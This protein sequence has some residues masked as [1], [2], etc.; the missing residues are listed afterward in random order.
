MTEAQTLNISPKKAQT[1]AATDPQLAAF[2]GSAGEN[3]A[4]RPFTYHAS[5]AELDELRRRI[6]A[7]RLPE[8]EPVADFSQGVPLATV[9]KLAR[10]CAT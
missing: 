7:T 3:K 2:R 4:I 8:K 1:I 9:H 5:Q 10:Y 6:V